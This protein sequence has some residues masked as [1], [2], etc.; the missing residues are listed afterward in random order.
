M[1]HDGGS[2]ENNDD[3]RI[4]HADSTIDAESA[5]SGT[6]DAESASGGSTD[7][8]STSSGTI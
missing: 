2:D 4:G 1:R 8:E 6:T 7:A 3:T 5:S